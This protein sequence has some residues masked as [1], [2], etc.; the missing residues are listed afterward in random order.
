[1]NNLIP[2]EVIERKIYLIRGQKVMLDKDLAVLYGVKTKKLNQAVK[3]NTKRF[4]LDFMFKL[5]RQETNK[6][7]LLPIRHSRSQIV[8]LK[9]GQNIKYSPFAFTEQGIAMLSSVLRS[10]KAIQVNVAIIR[11]FVKL[12][13]LLSGHSKLAKK[14]KELED[15]FGKHDKEIQTIFNVI[16]QMLKPSE[17][18]RPKIGFQPNKNGI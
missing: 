10:E 12:R 6:F 2:S 16:K 11:T 1:M 18:P 13:K 4:P 17:K 3:R 7:K 5:T 8:T 14:I 15:K 9:R